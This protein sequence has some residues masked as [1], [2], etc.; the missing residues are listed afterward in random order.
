MTIDSD[1]KAVTVWD[2]GTLAAVATLHPAGGDPVVESAGLS[3]DGMTVV[4][5]RFRPG[6]SAELWDV[7]SGRPFA[8]LRLPSSALEEVLAEG[9]K[10]LNR[11]SLQQPKMALAG[12]VLTSSRA[13][14]SLLGGRP[15]PGTQGRRTKGLRNREAVSTGVR[16]G[17]LGSSSAWDMRRGEKGSGSRMHLASQRLRAVERVATTG[18]LSL[19]GCHR[20]FMTIT[21]TRAT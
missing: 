5:F 13:R 3:E 1:H 7:A 19:S 18:H 6:P 8:T 9:G 20:K 16:N 11:A 14:Y 21:G 10:S 2:V 15:V 4:M 12:G 17:H